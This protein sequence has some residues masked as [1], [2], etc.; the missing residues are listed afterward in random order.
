MNVLVYCLHEPLS[1]FGTKIINTT[2]VRMTFVHN[3]FGLPPND[4]NNLRVRKSIR[5]N[6]I[7]PF[8][9]I[10]SSKLSNIIFFSHF[11]FQKAVVLLIIVL[12][13]IGTSFGKCTEKKISCGSHS[14]F[15]VSSACPTEYSSGQK[16]SSSEYSTISNG[17]SCYTK[18]KQCTESSSTITLTCSQMRDDKEET[19]L[20]EEEETMLEEVAITSAAVLVFAAVVPPPLPMFP[21]QGLP[22]PQALQGD[23]AQVAGGGILPSAALSVSH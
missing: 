6:C 4:N 9:H 18:V 12:Y 10:L 2:L 23:I 17:A 1:A 19:M 5:M 11:S 14:K 8:V 20:I 21:P 15:Y 22:Q 7:F 16:L 13:N 3:L